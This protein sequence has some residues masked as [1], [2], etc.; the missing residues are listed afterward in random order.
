MGLNPGQIVIIA[1]GF[2]I[3]V[4][5]LLC[6]GKSLLDIKNLDNTEITLDQE[7]QMFGQ[8][9][10]SIIQTISLPSYE[11]AIT[12]QKV[13]TVLQHQN[14]LSYL[15]QQSHHL[16]LILFQKFETKL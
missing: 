11:N 8:R 15:F 12:F 7:S 2:L 6:M 5:I 13:E 9:H 1:C 14:I 4:V 16:L 3:L 10:I